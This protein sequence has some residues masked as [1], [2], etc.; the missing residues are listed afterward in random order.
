MSYNFNLTKVVRKSVHTVVVDLLHVPSASRSLYQLYNRMWFAV[1]YQ[2]SQPLGETEPWYRKDIVLHGHW[3][4]K[5]ALTLLCTT[6][7]CGSIHLHISE[8]LI[9]RALRSKLVAA[10]LLLWFACIA[11]FVD[12]WNGAWLIYKIYIVKL[13]LLGRSKVY[14][15]TLYVLS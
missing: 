11:R 4:T 3:S 15:R 13:N 6:N 9:P 8:I 10:A 12:C 7:C 14:L 1:Q 5:A 2:I